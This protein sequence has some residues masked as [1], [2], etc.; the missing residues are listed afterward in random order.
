MAG[1]G[2]KF[3]HHLN[4][5]TILNNKLNS[6]LEQSIIIRSKAT[7][8][9]CFLISSKCRLCEWSLLAATICSTP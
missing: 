8:V 1:G 2:G 7:K 4:I 9:V 5:L 6:R 3:K